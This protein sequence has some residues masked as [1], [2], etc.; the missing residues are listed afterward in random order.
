MSDSREFGDL[1]PDISDSKFLG[2]IPV[3]WLKDGLTNSE[4]TVKTS[5]ITND[6]VFSISSWCVIL[7]NCNRDVSCHRDYSARLTDNQRD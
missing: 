1:F 6:A 3:E 4:K 2:F 7:I 5:P